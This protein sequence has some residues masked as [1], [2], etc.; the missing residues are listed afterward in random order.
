MFK[1]D[2]KRS[3]RLSVARLD[4]MNTKI[5]ATAEW[6]G[7]SSLLIWHVFLTNSN[8]LRVNCPNSE[9]FW[10]IFSRIR[11]EYGPEKFRI[12]TLFTQ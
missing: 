4:K 6:V 8:A 5:T 11:T 7:L 12:P 9:F 1:N 2:D 10:S 3:K